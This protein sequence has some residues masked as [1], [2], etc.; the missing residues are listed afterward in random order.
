MTSDS[1]HAEHATPL[2]EALVDNLISYGG[3]AGRAWM[4]DFPALL[5]RVAQAWQLLLE[6]PYEKLSFNYVTRVQLADSTPA[7]LKLGVP[8]DEKPTE[9]AW[10]RHYSDVRSDVRP[11]VRSGDV[12]LSDGQ[13]ARVGVAQV[14]RADPNI[15]ALLLTR[16]TPGDTLHA[17]PDEDATRVLATSM[18][19]LRRP[20]PPDAA[21][22]H[23]REWLTALPK[24]RE[25]HGGNGPLD[26]RRVTRAQS[27][28]EEL[29][30]SSTADVL[31]HG[32]LHHA[33]VLRHIDLSGATQWT[34]IDAKGVLG[35]ASYEVGPM[36]LNGAVEGRDLATVLP[37]M[38]RRL[39][40]LAA[41]LATDQQELTAWGFIQT[42]LSACWIV[43]AGSTRGLDAHQVLVAAMEA[44]LG[45]V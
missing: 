9:L 14:L 24:Y 34:V 33:N 12:A 25:R 21:F 16:L 44:C 6:A 30:R 27:L 42:M 31:L 7:I 20:P 22:P 18:A 8:S 45:S 38:R 13:I 40:L 15:S 5:Q 35:P 43:E 2:P 28:A 39:E 19:R 3:D 36:L 4:A 37:M 41:L 26:I 29:L 10:L 23:V 1:S 32:D 11:H 17:L